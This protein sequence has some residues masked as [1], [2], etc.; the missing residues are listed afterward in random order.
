MLFS[1][2]NE[3]NR[4]L[5]EM[6]RLLSKGMSNI[7]LTVTA[8]KKWCTQTFEEFKKF[9]SGSI[10]LGAPTHQLPMNFQTCGCNLKIGGPGAKLCVAFLLFYLER[11]MTF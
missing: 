1:S 6:N 3:T 8:E 10:F 9:F 5:N 11:I 2:V 4:L 7:Y